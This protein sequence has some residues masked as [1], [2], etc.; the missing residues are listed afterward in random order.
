MPKKKGAVIGPPAFIF[1]P[2]RYKS[3]K[4]EDYTS[5]VLDASIVQE[6]IAYLRGYHK[7]AEHFKKGMLVEAKYTKTGKFAGQ[8]YDCRLVKEMGGGW[9]VDWCDQDPDDR[10]KEIA[11]IRLKRSEPSVESDCSKACRWSRKFCDRCASMNI[12]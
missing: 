11:D 5:I 1:K 7:T 12:E 6:D 8:W 2:G 10:Q 4:L 3:I 9:L